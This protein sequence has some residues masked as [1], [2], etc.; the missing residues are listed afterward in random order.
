[1]DNTSGG[2]T[3]FYEETSTTLQQGGGAE[4]LRNFFSFLLFML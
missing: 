3:Y 2:L 4:A 1:M